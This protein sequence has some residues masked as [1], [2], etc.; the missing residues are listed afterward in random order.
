MPCLNRI[1]FLVVRPDTHTHNTEPANVRFK[2]MVRTMKT[3][4]GDIMGKTGGGKNQ[5]AERTMNSQTWQEKP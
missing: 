1:Y 4:R 3:L 5:E 2:I